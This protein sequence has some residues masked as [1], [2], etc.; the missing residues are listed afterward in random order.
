[1]KKFRIIAILIFTMLLSLTIVGCS[2]TNKYDELINKGYT[3]IVKYDPN[4]GNVIGS[5]NVSLTD[6]FNPDN[7]AK[8]ADG[9]VNIKLMNPTSGNRHISGGSKITISRSGYFLAGWYEKRALKKDE[10]GNVLDWEGNVLKEIDGVYYRTDT[11]DEVIGYPACTS[12][13]TPWNFE[14]DTVTAKSGEKLEKTLYAGWV[15]YYQ[16]DYYCQTDD[17]A[18]WIKYAETTFD[19]S[20][21]YD[22]NNQQISDKN[23][24]YTP[25]YKDGAMNYKINNN[26]TFP[27]KEGYTFNSCYTDE[28]CTEKVVG[29]LKHGGTL[30]YATG[31]PDGRVQKVYVKFDKGDIYRI[32]KASDL[33]D[34]ANSKGIY[35]IEADLDFS[36]TA[37]PTVFQYNGFNGKFYGQNHT[38]KNVNAQY[39][40]TGS[41]MGGLFGNIGDNAVVKDFTIENVTYD[42]VSTKNTKEGDFGLFAG[43]ISEKSSVSDV[44]LRGEITL[45]L[46][47]IDL[48]MRTDRED[49]P[50]LYL[51]AS[52]KVSGITCDQSKIKLIVYGKA[53]GD[54]YR[55]KVN[56]STCA[57]DKNGRIIYTRLGNTTD[58]VFTE[59]EYEITTNL[60]E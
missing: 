22:K 24:L 13:S 43:S 1:M 38:I 27:D 26:Y 42:Y 52:G 19:Y 39:K 41:L 34:N 5:Q 18:S 17:G 25:S 29:S 11:K 56:P 49:N 59:K 47:Y 4:G 44:I 57:V 23:T 54:K 53:H 2:D 28:G 8:S 60:G 10:K 14:T 48:D 20:A 21:A 12:Y 46:G 9:T 32:Q 3:V 35:Y 45:K 37:W 16:F 6:M 40:S 58:S 15:P 31:L 33:F 7:Y 50:Y 36:Q 30:D 55:Y 51:L